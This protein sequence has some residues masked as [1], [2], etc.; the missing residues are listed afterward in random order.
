LKKKKQGK[1]DET[2]FEDIKREIAIMKKL[3]H[4]NILRLFEVLD[5]PKVNKMY[6]VLEY[7]KR[8]DLVNVL[9]KRGGVDPNAVVTAETQF[10]PLSDFEV[11]N[12]TRQLVAGIRYLHFQNVIHGDIKPQVTKYRVADCKLRL[13][14][15]SLYLT[16]ILPLLSC[17]FCLH[18]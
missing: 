14:T 7:M 8:G 15:F 17:S 13:I 6:L 10:S 1:S 18:P 3:L 2:Y 12:I 5:D 9:K 11:W 4:P 16:L